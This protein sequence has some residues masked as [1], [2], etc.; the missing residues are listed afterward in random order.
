[1]LEKRTTSSS[2]FYQNIRLLPADK[3]FAI[4]TIYGFSRFLFA[5]LGIGAASVSMILN[6]LD[7]FESELKVAFR[8][9]DSDHPVI[10]GFIDVATMNTIS[11]A[12]TLYFT[13]GVRW[14]FEKK[15][16]ESCDAL[17]DYC[18]HTMSIM[19]TM[20]LPI[21]EYSDQAAIQQF[22]NLGIA[23]QLT[24]ILNRMELDSQRG[25]CYMPQDEC[26]QFNVS[27]KQFQNKRVTPE[28]RQLIKLQV[29]RAKTYYDKGLSG[30]GLLNVS[31]QY[32]V[33]S[34]TKAYQ[35][36]LIYLECANYDPYSQ[37]KLKYR[38][39]RWRL[40]ASRVINR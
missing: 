7:S 10:G 20:M 31:T 35:D 9:G 37:K 18:R 1:M 14:F 11:L 26:D 13:A 6:E 36:K 39:R 27:I 22:T 8:T 2:P 19:T 40:Q 28:F 25:V 34:F 3:R 38:V 32:A 33:G 4:Q 17:F 24:R 16:Y 29:N 5:G 15:Q 30:I 21:L 23:I 12:D